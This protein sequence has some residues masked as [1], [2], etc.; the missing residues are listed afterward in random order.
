MRRKVR[1]DFFVASA[2]SLIRTVSSHRYVNQI[3]NRL[4]KTQLH[5]SSRINRVSSVTKTTRG[6]QKLEI[7][8]EDDNKFVYD[9]VIFACHSDDA[10]R[11]LQAADDVRPDEERIL[12]SFG[13]NKNEVVLHSDPE[14]S[15][16]PPVVRLHPNP[17]C[18][19][20]QRVEWHGPVGIICRTQMGAIMPMSTVSRCMFNLSP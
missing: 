15:D 9:H 2:S 1:L 4:P 6:R 18:S 3:L 12:G 17:T 20:C 10:L 8:T 14:V 7:V 11:I 13:W 5:L 19:S 16:L